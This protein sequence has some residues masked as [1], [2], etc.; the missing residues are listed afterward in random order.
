MSER[1][2]GSVTCD[3]LLKQKRKL[4]D[5]SEFNHIYDAYKIIPS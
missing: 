4:P 5:E 3:N 1:H 2:L